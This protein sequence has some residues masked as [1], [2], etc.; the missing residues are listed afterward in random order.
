M[1]VDGGRARGEKGRKWG[2][3]TRRTPW[4]EQVYN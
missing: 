4:T 1:H 2:D 3:E